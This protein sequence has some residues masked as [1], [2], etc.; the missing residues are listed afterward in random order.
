MYY[1][2]LRC[3]FWND[4]I[5]EWEILVEGIEFIIDGR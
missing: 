2:S 5:D 3:H 1:I 4:L